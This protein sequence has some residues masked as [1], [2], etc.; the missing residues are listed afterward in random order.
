M[1]MLRQYGRLLSL[2][3]FSPVNPAESIL[4]VQAVSAGEPPVLEQAMNDPIE[5]KTVTDAASEF[6]HDDCAVSLE[7]WWGLWRYEKEWK[8]LPTRIT[9]SCYGPNYADSP[10]GDEGLAAEHLRIDFGL[11]GWYLPNGELPNSAWYAKSNLKGLMKLIHEL[12]EALPVERRALWSEGGGNFA[13]KVRL[14]A[15][16]L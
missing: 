6:L 9:L 3:P 12:D 11:E 1:T 16:E 15:A 7:T 5:A 14:A 2:F 10:F 4:R 8:L 13:D